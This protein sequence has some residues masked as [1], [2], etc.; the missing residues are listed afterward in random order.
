MKSARLVSIFALLIMGLS[1]VSAQDAMGPSVTVSNQI[2]LNGNVV[3]GEVVSAGAGFIVIHAD[4]AGSFGAV[5]GYAPVADGVNSNVNVQFDSASATPTLYAMLHTDSGDAGVYEFGVV[6]GADGPV[7]VDGAAVSP[8]FAVDLLDANDQFYEGNTVNIDSVVVQQDGFVVVHADNEGS[9]G[10]VL[11]F[12]PVT[13]GVN[14]N[15]AVELSGDITNVLF[16]MLHI[17]T[18]EAGVYEFGTVEG[19]DGPVVIDG[20]VAVHAITTNTPLM[21]ISDQVVVGGLSVESVLAESAGWV[22][23]HADNGEGGPGPVIGQALIEAGLTNNVMVEV[24]PMGV[25]PVLFPMLHVDTG[26]AG[27]YE[28]GAVEGADGPVILDGA[29]YFFAID[30]APSI[31]YSGSLEGNIVTIDAVLIDQPG[32]LVIHA[33]NEGS[34]GAVLGYAPILSGVNYNV[35]VVL[36]EANMTETVWPMLHYDTNVMGEYEFGTVEG[37]DG[38]VVVGESVITGP[39][40]P[41]SME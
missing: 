38:P 17:D 11:G 24:D 10:A 8:P 5:I 20:T 32:W 41:G 25:T 14:S 26:E 18:G 28:F 31:T 36:D 3:V 12:T 30:A 7:V 22:V 1:V 33:E 27:V 13:A 2:S 16:P 4:N 6:E 9:F 15:V 29:P 23:I 34:F 35:S 21:A 39:W 40:T 19:A 37:A